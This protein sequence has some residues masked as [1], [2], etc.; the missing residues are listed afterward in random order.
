VLR[1]SWRCVFQF[2]RCAFLSCSFALGLSTELYLNGADAARRAENRSY[3]R[4]H[5]FPRAGLHSPTQ[6]YF[7][8]NLHFFVLPR[9]FHSWNLFSLLHRSFADNRGR[10]RFPPRSR[11]VPAGASGSNHNIHHRGNTKARTPVF[12][13]L[14]GIRNRRRTGTAK[15]SRCGSGK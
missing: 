11:A 14:S 4:R 2:V 10:T 1:V 8:Y 12:R 15:N 7:H 13:R 5:S 9:D 3:G 6:R